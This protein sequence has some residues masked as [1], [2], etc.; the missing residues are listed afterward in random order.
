MKRL[1]A[2]LLCLAVLCVAGCGNTE[3]DTTSGRSEQT[4][5]TPGEQI[6][7]TPGDQTAGTEPSRTVETAE[8][9]ETPSESF[10]IVGPYTDILKERPFDSFR[11]FEGSRGVYVGKSGG[12]EPDFGIDAAP[13][14]FLRVRVVGIKEGEH[15]YGPQRI[16]SIYYVQVTAAYNYGDSFSD[17]FGEDFTYGAGEVY[18]LYYIGT[19]EH[20]LYGRPPLEIGKEYLELNASLSQGEADLSATL[21]MPIEEIDG[22]EYVYGYGIDLGYLDCAIA[23]T[24]EE[25][26]Q[27]YKPGK[28]DS[29]IAQVLADGEELPT[30]D[31]KCK[32]TD[33]IEENC[34]FSF[35]L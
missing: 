24:D 22:V 14:P 30:F 34:K 13:Y 16:L 25:E 8:T 5:Q 35:I 4:D 33:L 12:L 29:M 11:S 15:N 17:V 10:E 32:L 21:M 27:I 9:T 2:A 20:P 1:L 18:T 31:Y 6:T 23:I 19:P 26:N 3:S 28:H 7:E